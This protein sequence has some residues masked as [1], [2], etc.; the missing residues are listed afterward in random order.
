MSNTFKRVPETVLYCPPCADVFGT[1]DAQ[2]KRCGCANS[3]E[4]APF[5]G[6][7]EYGFEACWYCQAEII[8]SGSRWSTFYCDKCRP[9]VIR[10]NDSLDARGLA[11]L[12]IG[13]H[14]LMHGHW[15]HARPFTAKGLVSDWRTGRLRSGWI[16]YGGGSTPMP[17][18]PFGRFQRPKK[19]NQRRSVLLEI[20]GL[21]QDAPGDWVLESL[22][23]VNLEL[24]GFRAKQ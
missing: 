10:T 6:D 11:S 13:R 8:Q 22:R 14:S 21:V 2:T 9:H 20:A 5:R 12:P 24:H 4:V 7:L 18:A 16:A 15:A 1:I 23:A 3:E 17:W 19:A